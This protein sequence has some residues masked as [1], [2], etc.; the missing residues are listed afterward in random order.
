MTFGAAVQDDGAVKFAGDAQGAEKQS[1]LEVAWWMFTWMGVGKA[2]SGVIFCSVSFRDLDGV[3]GIR[4]VGDMSDS[5]APP[6][7]GQ[8]AITVSDVAAAKLFYRDVLGLGFLFDAGPNLAF[9]QAGEVR[10]MLTTPQGH[11]EPGKN[12][13]LYFKVAGIA[14]AY[15]AMI[16]R[17]ATA[18]R[19]P[20]Q[21]AKM[22]DHDLWMGFVRD[23]DGN[24]VG[25]MEEVR[26]P[27][28]AES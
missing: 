3:R 28:A 19:E 8:V 15:A 22:P 11:G 13:V 20:G 27:V 21:T 2:V 5:P 18:E 1:I 12:S 25:L 14:E 7:L 6:S 4:M 9:L 17:G 26:P 10:V 23:S 16:G 24:L